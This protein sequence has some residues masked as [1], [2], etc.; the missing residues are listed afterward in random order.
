MELGRRSLDV[1][2]EANVHNYMGKIK[3]YVEFK[4]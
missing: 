4:K 1:W 3:N 2:L